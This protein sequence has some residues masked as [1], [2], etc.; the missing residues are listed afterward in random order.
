MAVPKGGEA[1]AFLDG[2]FSSFCDW[3]AVDRGREVLEVL[4]DAAQELYV[5][6]LA[7]HHLRH[8]GRRHT[9]LKDPPRGQ[10]FW[11][12]CEWGK[13]D[14]CCGIAREPIEDWDSDYKRNATGDLALI[15][16]KVIYKHYSPSIKSAKVQE[17]ASKLSESAA[18]AEYPGEL[19]ALVWWL[20]YEEPAKDEGPRMLL[21]QM[22]EE[23]GLV[24]RGNRGLVRVATADLR[25]AWPNETNGKPLDAWLLVGLYSYV[26]HGP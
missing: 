13:T 6:A 18:D 26:R 2:W 10:L 12:R 21:E 17:L 8:Y 11:A 20:T 4:S 14:I 3:L 23:K 9:A 15:E 22:L 19:F 24:R 7:A 25:S 5:N 1:G 16:A